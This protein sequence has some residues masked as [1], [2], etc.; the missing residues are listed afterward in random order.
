MGG[1]TT[2]S[3]SEGVHHTYKTPS[4]LQESSKVTLS[5]SWTNN[6]QENWSV[7]SDNCSYS[8]FDSSTSSTP[9]A[10]ASHTLIWPSTFLNLPTKFFSTPK[11]Q[12]VPGQKPKAQSETGFCEQRLKNSRKHPLRKKQFSPFSEFK[13]EPYSP[14]ESHCDTMQLVKDENVGGYHTTNRHIEI[15]SG[16]AGLKG[17]GNETF[18][19]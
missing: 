18:Y 17:G 11:S 4:P 5:P 19:K 12:S 7:I 6:R 2:I 13:D 8:D 9:T 1:H 3:H 14:C 10:T 15:K 16:F